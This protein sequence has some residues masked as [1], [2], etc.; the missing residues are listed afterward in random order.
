QPVDDVVGAD[1]AFV[2]RFQRDEHLPAIASAAAGEADYAG[3]G[4]IGTDD[5]DESRQLRLHRLERGRLIGL[6]E[7]HDAASVLLR[8]EALGNHTVQIEV[9]ADHRHQDQHHDARMAQCPVETAFVVA[10][11]PVEYAFA[12]QI[13]AIAFLFHRL[14]PQ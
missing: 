11:H 4:R 2:Q 12:G 9:E 10:D 8:E 6:D 5:V 7:A 1:L 3:D 13:P 14:A